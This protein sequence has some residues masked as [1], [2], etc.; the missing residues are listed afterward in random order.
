MSEKFDNII[1]QRIYQRVPIEQIKAA[2]IESFY[3]AGN[4]LNKQPPNDIDI[5]PV[6][7]LFTKD[8]ASKLGNIVSE[9]KNAT[10]IKVPFNG[11]LHHQTVDGTTDIEF[12]GK[13]ITIQLCNYHHESLEKLVNS[14]DFSHIQIGALVDTNKYDSSKNIEVYYTKAYEDA[15]M[16]QSTEYVGSEYPLSS[17]IRAFKYSKRGDFAGNSHIFSVFKLLNDIIIRGFNDFEDFKNQ[18]DAIDLGLVPE[19]PKELEEAGM[20]S[21]GLD[22]SEEGQNVLNKLMNLLIIGRK[23]ICK[24]APSAY[25]YAKLIGKRFEEGE[26]IIALDGKISCDYAKFIMKGR[27]EKAENTISKNIENSLRYAAIIGERFEKA[28]ETFV[29]CSL[30]DISKTRNKSFYGDFCSKSEVLY[31]YWNIL[32]Y[33]CPQLPEKLHNMMI[34]Y[35]MDGDVFAKEYISVIARSKVA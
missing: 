14:F 15:K 23:A 22:F 24:D 16:C 17:L 31:K 25:E 2:G 27:F 7:S 19:N 6:A 20:A 26:N 13:T 10:T 11:T 29:S 33:S 35:S 1:R 21:A 18:L 9:T 32:K 12:S 30:P 5:F 8:Q 3:V 28:E 34:A 4:S